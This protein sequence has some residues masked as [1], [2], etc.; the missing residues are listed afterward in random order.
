MQILRSTFVF[1]VRGYIE[2]APTVKADMVFLILL[3]RGGRGTFHV[4]YFEVYVFIV[5]PPLM[6]E[7]LWGSRK[8]T[9]GQRLPTVSATALHYSMSARTSNKSDFIVEPSYC[10][11]PDLCSVITFLS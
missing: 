10:R 7:D 8:A 6:F 4:P 11:F 2:L 1:A 9:R 5:W 3:R